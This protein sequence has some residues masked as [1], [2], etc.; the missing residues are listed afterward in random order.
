[1]L[2]VHNWKQKPDMTKLAVERLVLSRAAQSCRPLFKATGLL[3][4]NN[5]FSTLHKIDV[6]Y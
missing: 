2:C 3:S 1:M 6:P 4:E 5:P